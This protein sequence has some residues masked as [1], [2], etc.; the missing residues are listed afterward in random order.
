MFH[1]SLLKQY[2][3]DPSHVLNDEDTIFLSQDE[4]QMES[5]QI[6]EVKE[7]QLRQRIIREVFV[8]WK[9]YPIEDASWEYWDRLVTQF[10][11]VQTWI[12]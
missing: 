6:L 5:E 10:P 2:I 12:V 11:H 4:F 8:L 3:A 7:W 9:N 1:V